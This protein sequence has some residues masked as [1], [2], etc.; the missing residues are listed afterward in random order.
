MCHKWNQEVI[1]GVEIDR[2]WT[3]R[4]K[5]EVSVAGKNTYQIRW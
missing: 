4:S 3:V 5:T 1:D 2:N